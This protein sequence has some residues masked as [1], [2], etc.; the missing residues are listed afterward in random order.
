MFSNE[1]MTLLSPF[2]G[3]A[4][5]EDDLE[6]NAYALLRVNNNITHLS[7]HVILVYD[8]SEYYQ[9]IIDRHLSSIDNYCTLPNAS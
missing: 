2:K 6:M 3:D 4:L 7:T 1:T 8:F 9:E 5:F